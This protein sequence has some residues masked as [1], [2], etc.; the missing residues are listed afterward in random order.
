MV[1]FTQVLPATLRARLTIPAPL[2]EY[3]SM[4]Q[5][6]TIAG[7]SQATVFPLILTYHLSGTIRRQFDHRHHQSI[8]QRLH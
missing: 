1:R 2:S 7:R 8:D 6:E 3:T 4:A 5:I